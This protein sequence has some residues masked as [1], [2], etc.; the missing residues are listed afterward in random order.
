[1]LIKIINHPRKQAI[2][3]TFTAINTEPPGARER[4]EIV[5]WIISERKKEETP[6]NTRDQG[7]SLPGK[8]KLCLHKLLSRNFSD[9][10]RN[11]KLSDKI[12][13]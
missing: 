10:L 2:I 13:K 9:V 1:M 3:L 11:Y 6:G 4:E 7:H 5:L 8:S 12:V